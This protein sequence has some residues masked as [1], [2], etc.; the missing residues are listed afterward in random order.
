MNL[1]LAEKLLGRIA[2]AI[3]KPRFMA[4]C[5]Q[6][7]RHRIGAYTYGSPK[8]YQWDDSTM[9]TI[10]KHCSIAKDV[11]IVLGGEH[12]TDWITTYPFNK[13]FR[14]AA[15]ITGHPHSKGDV[16]IG[17]DVWIGMGATILSGVTIGDGAVIAAHSLV[18]RNV[19]P[20]AIAGGNPARVIRSRFP[21]DVVRKLQA[22]AWWDWP[23]EKIEEGVPLLTHNDIGAFIRWSDE[24]A[25]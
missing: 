3:R 20:Y 12:R 4:D 19:P 16:N 1:K 18:T 11:S 24:I 7:R 21:V 10:G 6:Y 14:E 17:N 2:D 23:I 22:I 8:I 13:F 5:H 15:G 25:Q 9:L